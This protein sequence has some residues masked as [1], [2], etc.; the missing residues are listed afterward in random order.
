M[1]FKGYKRSD[2]RAGTR[3]YVGI[4]STVVC[5]NEV[6]DAIARQVQGTACFMHQQGCCQSSGILQRN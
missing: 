6:A 4:L 2:G 1:Q 3:N 5:A